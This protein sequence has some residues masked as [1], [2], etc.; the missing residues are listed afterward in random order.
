MPTKASE[1]FY[2]ED[3]DQRF[4]RCSTS[5]YVHLFRT[6]KNRCRNMWSKLEFTS[7]AEVLL[8]HSSTV[9]MLRLR[10]Q[11]SELPLSRARAPS[12]TS[13]EPVN[14]T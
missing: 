2:V 12:G 1:A 13:F 6:S 8:A 3:I 14:G 11:F 4:F 7:A 10:E 5:Q 9:G